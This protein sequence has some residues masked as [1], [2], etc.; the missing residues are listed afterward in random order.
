MRQ[1][2]QS[3][4]QPLTGYYDV[5]YASFQTA[6]YAGIRRDA[7]GEDIGQNSWLTVK[8]QD[9]F[10]GWLDLSSGKTLLMLPAVQEARPCGWPKTP[11]VLLL[12]S[13]CM[14]GPFSR[15]SR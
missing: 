11:V 1:P 8:E 4:A 10:L 3:K 5:N 13:I 15:Q 2:D 12:G 9:M 7:F 14:S 6:L